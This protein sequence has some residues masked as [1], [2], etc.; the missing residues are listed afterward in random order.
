MALTPRLRVLH[1][2][3]AYRPGGMENMIAQMAWRLPNT[4]FEVAI[5][6]LTKSDSF[7]ER[8]PSGIQVFEL[9]KPSGLSLSCFINLRRLIKNFDPDVIHSHNWDG[10]IYTWFASVFTDRVILH[11]EH[12]QLYQWERSMWRLVLRRT[13]YARCSLVHTVSNGQAD[14]LFHY[15]LTKCVDFKVIQNGVDTQKFSPVDKSSCRDHF[16]ISKNS[17]CL[18]MV[19]RCIADKR[20]YLLLEAFNELAPNFPEL[21][22]VFAGG[23]GTVSSK[24]LV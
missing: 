22:L 13:L 8:L 18:G 9:F 15:G 16:G 11:G 23:G 2:L 21:M 1:V 6:A 10:L 5:C 24:F 12:A 20:H 7:K 4:K 3:H 19:A 14:E 17:F